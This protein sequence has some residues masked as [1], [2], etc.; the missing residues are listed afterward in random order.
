MLGGKYELFGQANGTWNVNSR[1]DERS[2]VV[3]ECSQVEKA[4][5]LAAFC[6]GVLVFV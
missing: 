3:C 4:A 2:S 5:F 6:F 1:F